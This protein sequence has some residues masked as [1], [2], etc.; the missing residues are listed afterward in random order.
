MSEHKNEV[1]LPCGCW[2][3]IR[4]RL[5]PA[6]REA[7]VPCDCGKKPDCR[8]CRGTG[9]AAIRGSA[10]LENGGFKMV[11][12]EELEDVFCQAHSADVLDR[13]L[14]VQAMVERSG[15]V[16]TEEAAALAQRVLVER[17]DPIALLDAATEAAVAREAAAER[18]LPAAATAEAPETD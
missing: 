7:D 3:G 5:A 12:I 4:K 11:E 2:R 6:F 18:A 13:Q 14:A 16:L 8:V 1:R 15:G 17:E 9:L 10:I